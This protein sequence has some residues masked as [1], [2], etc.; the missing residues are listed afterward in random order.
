MNP[1]AAA[2]SRTRQFLV[3]ALYQ[4][5]L[6][7]VDY[8]DV[9]TPFM[10][11]HNMKRAD[12]EYFREV[13]RGIGSEEEELVSLIESKSDRKFAELDPVEKGILLMSAFE[14]R[15]RIEVPYRVVINEAIELAKSFGA[16]DSYRY[17]NT[18]LD[19]LARELRTLE[20]NG[21]Q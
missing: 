5:Q 10:N 9:M 1:S 13:I 11:D 4:A 14:L 7:E 15:S 20:Q 17:V 8:V 21:N 2:R 19:G 3:Q 12:L 6:T 18:I 16:T